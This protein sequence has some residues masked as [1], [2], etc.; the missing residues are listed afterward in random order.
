MV[1]A[2]ILALSMPAA[3]AALAE[4]WLQVARHGLQS[5]EIRL[6]FAERGQI[7]L[8]ATFINR[9]QTACALQAWTSRILSKGYGA[10]DAL[11]NLAP[12][13]QPIRR[14]GTLPGRPARKGLSLTM[15]RGGPQA[16]AVTQTVQRTCPPRKSDR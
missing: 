15:G 11:A 13:R 5:P 12:G 6:E 1:S 9:P 7:F 3:E 2:C 16:R 14:G 10:E 4:L 8:C